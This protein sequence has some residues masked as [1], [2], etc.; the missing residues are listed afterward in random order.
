MSDLPSSNVFNEKIKALYHALSMIE[1]EGRSAQIS[2]SIGIVIS[3][4]EDDTFEELYTHADKALYDAKC[5]GGS[6]YSVY[7]K[8]TF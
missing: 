1:I 4:A 8:N 3:K 6:K 5:S 2:C 7:G